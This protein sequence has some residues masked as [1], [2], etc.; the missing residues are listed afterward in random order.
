M[1][2]YW[3]LPLIHN[4]SVREQVRRVLQVYIMCW[5]LC[6]RV[7]ILR[8][9]HDFVMVMS[10]LEYMI[11]YAARAHRL[12]THAH[13]KDTLLVWSPIGTGLYRFIYFRLEKMNTYV[14]NEV[15]V[16]T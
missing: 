16:R 5:Y 11:T 1:K 4:W 12:N 6:V 10:P 2:F 13:C 7:Y 15:C 9:Q 8:E 14:F 3:P